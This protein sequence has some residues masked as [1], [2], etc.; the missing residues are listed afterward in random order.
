MLFI[1]FILDKFVTP[2]GLEPWTLSLKVR[3]STNWAKKSFARNRVWYLYCNRCFGPDPITVASILGYP[4]YFAE[5]QGSGTFTRPSAL[6]TVVGKEGLEPPSLSER[7]YSPSS[8]PIAQLP[9]IKRFPHRQGSSSVAT[10]GAI[11]KLAVALI[12]AVR[13]ILF[14]IRLNIPSRYFKAFHRLSS[15]L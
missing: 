11:F 1:L 15:P 3:C 12:W 7:I 2:Q 6:L 10:I 14:S 5:F 8:Q 13:C 4:S 9:I